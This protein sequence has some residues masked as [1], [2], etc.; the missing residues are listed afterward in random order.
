MVSRNMEVNRR[1]EIKRRR[2]RVVAKQKTMLGILA[3]LIISLIIIFGSAMITFAKNENKP[4]P[5]KSYV[6]IQV[7]NGD[8]LWSIAESYTESYDI[9]INDYINE[10]K[11]MNSLSSDDIHTGS[12]LIIPTYHY[13]EI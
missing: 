1:V 7:Q 6:S 5:I 9:K 13:E 8:T 10:V 4:E 11:S 12:F 3:V 2:E